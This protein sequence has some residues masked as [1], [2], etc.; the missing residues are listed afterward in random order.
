[1]QTKCAVGCR[2]MKPRELPSLPSTKSVP[3][4]HALKA[5]E[6]HADAIGTEWRVR[7]QTKANRRAESANAWFKRAAYQ[8][9]A[10]Y[11]ELGLTRLF[12]RIAIQDRRPSRLVREALKNP[13]KLGLL[14]MFADEETELSRKDRHVFGNQMLYA[15]AHDVPPDFLNAFL[16]VTGGPARVAQKLKDGEAEPGFEHR[17]R[18]DRLPVAER[19]ET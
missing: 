16:A 5:F 17:F 15:W 8:L 1:M 18:Q 11:V 19:D 10:R 3:Q 2:A 6:A 9:L 12:E 4:T 7:K 13:F 14:A